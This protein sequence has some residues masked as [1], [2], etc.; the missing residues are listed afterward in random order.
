M[1]GRTALYNRILRNVASGQSLPIGRSTGTFAGGTT[2]LFTTGIVTNV[3]KADVASLTCQRN[4][5]MARRTQL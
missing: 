5:G 3:V 4:Q 2:A 1:R